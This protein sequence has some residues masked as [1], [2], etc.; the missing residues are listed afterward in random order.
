MSIAALERAVS[1]PARVRGVH[2][3]D[4]LARQIAIDAAEGGGGLPL[5]EFALTELW[6]RQH[7]R[8][9]TFAEYQL[10]GGVAGA[11]DRYA[12]TVFAELAARGLGDRVR[13]VMLAL[14]RSR[15]GAAQATRRVLGR[16]RLTRDW[17]VV[18]ELARYRLLTIE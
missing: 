3:D 13:R 2:Y 17:D 1:E 8:R 7:R 4:G 18:E 11:L 15:E 12:E 6:A 10:F 9:L 16:D 14:V 5:M